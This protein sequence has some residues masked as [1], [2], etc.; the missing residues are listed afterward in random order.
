MWRRIPPEQVVDDMIPVFVLISMYLP[1]SCS[2]LN[3]IECFFGGGGGQWSDGL[4]VPR[5]KMA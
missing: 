5:R 2:T 1:D 3:Q 4:A